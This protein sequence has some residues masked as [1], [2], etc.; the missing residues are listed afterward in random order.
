[1][2]RLHDFSDWDYDVVYHR[3]HPH[4][5]TVFASDTA[6]LTAESET[7][8]RST[9]HRGRATGREVWC[10]DRSAPLMTAG[11]VVA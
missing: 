1:M 5:R 8:V 11:R 2:D 6:K 9:P 3:P 7:W 4:R 10:V